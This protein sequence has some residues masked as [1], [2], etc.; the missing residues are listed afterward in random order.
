MRFDD[1]SA[2]NGKNGNSIRHPKKMVYLA[3]AAI[4][5]REANSIQIIKMCEAFAKEGIEVTLIVPDRPTDESDNPYE[6]Y[7]VDECFTIE[8]VPWKPGERYL[9]SLLAPYYVRRIRPDIVYGRFAPACFF[10]SLL[11]Y[12]V[13]FEAHEP[14]SNEMWIIPWM[15]RALLKLG[16]LKQLVVISEALKIHYLST[17]DC[18]TEDDVTVAHDAASKPEDVEPLPFADT[19][20]LQVGYVGHLY[21]GKGISVIAELISECPWADFHIVGG[22]PDDIMYWSRELQGYKNVCLHGFVPH[23]E[24]F[25]Y[26][27]S[28]DVLLAPYQRKVHGTSGKTDLSR[29]MSP[30]KIFEY[31]SVGKSIIC[32][33]LPVLREVLTDGDTALLASPDDTDEWVKMIELINHNLSIGRRLGERAQIEFREKHTYAAR[34]RHIISSVSVFS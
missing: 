14:V 18:L 20:R 9:F 8:R 12:R 6:F 3:D 21:E 32:S 30:L 33:D 26:L 17:Y 25:R 31:M 11:G 10:T 16:R 24:V 7:D 34:A 27:E 22:T 13:V 1:S 28:M 5:S 19:D 29:W 2:E 4:P 23:R 15:F